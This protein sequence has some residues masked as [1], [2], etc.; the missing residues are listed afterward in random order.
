MEQD[1]RV[2]SFLL[3]ISSISAVAGALAH[4]TPA[5][6]S[7]AA[8]SNAMHL[9]AQLNDENSMRCP[10][11]MCQGAHLSVGAVAGEH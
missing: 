11:C 8:V 1:G 9:W 2:E 3:Q 6:A 10:V 7:S 5:A 4:S